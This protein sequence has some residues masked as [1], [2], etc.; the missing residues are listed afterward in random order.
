MSDF[1]TCAGRN[2]SGRMARTAAQAASRMAAT[3]MAIFMRSPISL[4]ADWRKRNSAAGG[5]AADRG[6]ANFPKRLLT[7][8]Q[9]RTILNSARALERGRF[10][11]VTKRQRGLQ[12]TRQA[13][14]A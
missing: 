11:V 13:S 8:T 5:E 10:A 7:I 14:G 2:R 12:W 3:T 9:I 6:F 4:G 1:L